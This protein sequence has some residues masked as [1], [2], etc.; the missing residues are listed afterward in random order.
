M[1]MQVISSVHSVSSP[2]LLLLLPSYSDSL[3][4]ENWGGRTLGG[5]Y[6]DYCKAVIPDS[7]GFFFPQM[8]V[9]GK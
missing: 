3:T 8:L 6:N 9:P 1:Y 4:S 7:G 5:D 2:Y